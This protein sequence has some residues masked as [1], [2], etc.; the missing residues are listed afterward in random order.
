[1]TLKDT[2]QK[3]KPNKTMTKKNKEQTLKTFKNW[4][5]FICFERCVLS[6]EFKN[7]EWICAGRAEY[8]MHKRR[9][10]ATEVHLFD[11]QV[12]NTIA[13]ENEK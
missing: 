6:L 4:G 7:E 9:E 10:R 1:M 2:I 3:S 13:N 12:R 5:K 11:L 8:V